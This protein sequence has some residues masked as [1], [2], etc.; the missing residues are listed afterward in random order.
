[1]SDKGVTEAI[2]ILSL[3]NGVD[4]LLTWIILMQALWLHPRFNT[5]TRRL[6]S[7]FID[8]IRLSRKL[9]APIDRDALLKKTFP[10]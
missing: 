9:S 6:A 5:T 1:M 8:S 4:T 10:K 3:I 7:W 2:R